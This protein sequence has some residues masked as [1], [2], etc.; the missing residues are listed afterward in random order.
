MVFLFIDIISLY[1]FFTFI[2]EEGFCFNPL[3]VRASFCMSVVYT[4]R[5]L[6]KKKNL[7]ET[8]KEK[9]KISTYTDINQ[10]Q[11]AKYHIG[12]LGFCLVE[13]DFVIHVL[14]I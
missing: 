8:R 11:I 9:E 12:S 3:V 2:W 7:M 5:K 14:L 1:T 10:S 4:S 13:C 6:K